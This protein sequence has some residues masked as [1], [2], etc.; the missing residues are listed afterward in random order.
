MRVPAL[1]L[2]EW[3]PSFDWSEG[4]FNRTVL[5][6]ALWTL[7][8]FAVFLFANF[9]HGL[10]VQRALRAMELPGMRLDVAD[11]RFA[12]WRGFELQRVRLAPDDPSLPAYF[13]APSLY[14]RPG[15]SG[16][17]R[18]ELQSIDVSGTL[19]GGSIDGSISRGAT[20][21]VTL[22]FDGLQL[23]RYP[24]LASLLPEAQIDGALSGIVSV[25]TR[26]G[27]DLG[28]V[29]AAG[30][31]GLQAVSLNDANWNGIV[32][33][34][35]HFTTAAT[36]FSLQGG[37]LDLQDLVVDGKEIAVEGGGQVVVRQPVSDS[38]LNL[39]VAIAP[40]PEAPDE[41]KTVL[42]A[43]IPPPPR[44]AKPDAPRVIS[45]TLAKPR[46]R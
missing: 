19:Y 27:G 18:G 40:G 22:N 6:Y 41:I 14:V 10:L 33:P 2:P 45:G 35:L 12:W 23:Q 37:R 44:G 26:G 29:R 11:A 16:L 38:V 9:P 21:R 1:R 30:E 31:L 7:V 28:D 13:E 17:L 34:P 8:L 32:I 24:L 20:D 25:E 5:L 42:A 46:I 3:R 4:L 43:F 39:K 15:L 36:R